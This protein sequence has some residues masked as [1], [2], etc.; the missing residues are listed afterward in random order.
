MKPDTLRWRE[1]EFTDLP[2]A[3]FG[4]PKLQALGR[5]ALDHPGLKKNGAVLGYAD[6]GDQGTYLPPAI[7]VLEDTSAADV[8][9]WLKTYAPETSPL[10]QFARV[11]ARTDWEKFVVES[12]SAVSRGIRADRWACVVLGEFLAQ[13]DSG[14]HLR[15]LP[16]SWT[17][18]CFSTAIARAAIFY[19]D[20]GTFRECVDRLQVVE[21]D[22]RFVRRPTSVSSL[23]PVWT[24]VN[25]GIEDAD[26][27]Q[28]VTESVVKAAFKDLSDGNAG[29]ENRALS[30]LRQ[31]DGF[32]SDSVELRVAAFKNLVGQLR[33]EF[34][35]SSTDLLPNVL[36]AAG[37]FL[38]GRGT[39]HAF[40][41]QRVAR[42][43][44]SS[45]PWFATIASFGGARF[46]DLEW[47]RAAKGVERLLRSPFQWWGVTSADLCWAEYAWMAQTFAGTAAF[48]ELP[49]MGSK[50]L[51][52]E[53]IPGLQ[54]QFRLA[55][56]GG[57]SGRET[58]R[59]EHPDTEKRDRE[60]RV[61]LE[62]IA[63]LTSQANHLMDRGQIS[64]G[65]AVLSFED[66]AEGDLKVPIPKKPRRSSE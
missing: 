27:P 22:R 44:P 37:A 61:M 43:W 8:F 20:P 34:G 10:S 32:S 24:V 57:Q 17:A 30:T 25:S 31:K 52:V 55:D 65:Q 3:L 33:E 41:L 56:S 28:S 23:L 1:F 63:A 51:S 14:S 2:A 48:G 6:S 18:A 29:L 53:L 62:R 11:V 42:Q 26:E 9:S 4:S 5:A 16:L 13:D 21:N 36:V 7:I 64:K 39:S 59:S 40:L 58:D 50:V 38:V 49:K 35:A 12:P 54:C 46:W 47:S 66:S 45:L 60:L 15:V 19:S